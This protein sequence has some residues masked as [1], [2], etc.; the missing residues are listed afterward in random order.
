MGTAAGGYFM[1][2]VN[3]RTLAGLGLMTAIVIVLQLVGGAIRFGTF[4]IS[5]VLLP[6]VVGAALYGRGAGAWLGFVF[7]AAV[8]LSGDASAFLAVNVFGTLVTCLLKGALAG[9]CAGAVYK[10][11]EKTNTVLAT[12]LAAV[13]APIVNTGVFLLGCSVFFLDTVKG[14]AVAAGA[15]SVGAYM[16]VGFVGIN[17]LIELA[18]NIVLCP[19]IVRVVGAGKRIKA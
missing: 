10:L 14:W 15:E 16:F 2:K 4:S 11:F 7:G 19:V 5:L 12:A 18:V 17:F 13:A 9:L 3:T 6:I 1:K 8:I